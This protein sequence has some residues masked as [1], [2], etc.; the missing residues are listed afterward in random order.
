MPVRI[1]C[2]VEGQGEVQSVPALIHRICADRKVI[3]P[4][5]PRPIR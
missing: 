2:I 4:I 1:C 5:V 3:T